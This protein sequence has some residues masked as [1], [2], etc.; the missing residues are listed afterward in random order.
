ME[1]HKKIDDSSVF[2]EDTVTGDTQIINDSLDILENTP[3]TVISDEEIASTNDEY[4]KTEEL[5]F[6]KEAETDIPDSSSHILEAPFETE[7]DGELNENIEENDENSLEYYDDETHDE[8]EIDEKDPE[9]S[10]QKIIDEEIDE[11]NILMD[12]ESDEIFDEDDY[13]ASENT[14]ENDS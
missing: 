12:D 10:D 6:K 11:E 5:E 4:N 14:R 8:D 1:T 7:N 3:D 2:S 9:N 13:L